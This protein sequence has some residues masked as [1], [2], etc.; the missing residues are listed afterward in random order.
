MLETVLIGNF[1][2]KELNTVGYSYILDGFVKKS[3][4]DNIGGE[5]GN[6]F[7]S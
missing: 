3:K 5:K 1:L 6:S 4:R 7:P 2:A